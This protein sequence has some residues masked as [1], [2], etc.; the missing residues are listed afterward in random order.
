M[1]LPA[2]PPWPGTSSRATTDFT[3]ASRMGFGARTRSELVR[4]SGM[5]ET[6]EAPVPGAAAGAAWPGAGTAPPAAAACWSTSRWTSTARSE[7]TACCKGM[8]SRSVALGR[9]SAAMIL[10]SRRTF[11]A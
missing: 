4:K 8:T 10:P 6:P 2:A 5:I 9:S 1:L 11:S 7:A 3:I